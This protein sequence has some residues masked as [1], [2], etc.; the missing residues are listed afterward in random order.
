VRRP[1]AAALVG[2]VALGCAGTI[3]AE[4]GAQVRLLAEQAAA[5]DAV[6]LAQL[7]AVREVDGRRVNL[8]V[9]LRGAQGP[10]LA[11]RLAALGAPSNGAVT[12]V[13]PSGEAARI[14]AEDRFHEAGATRPLRG[15]LGWIGD[16]LEFLERPFG[17]LADRI[18]GGG[19]VLAVLVAL[20]VAGVAAFVASRVARRR[21]GAAVE[22]GGGRAWEDAEDPARLE[23]EADEAEQRGELEAALRLRFRAGLL[24]LERAAVIPADERTS[25]ELRRIVAQPEFDRLAAEFDAVAYGGRAATRNAVAA[26]RSSWR[27]VLE[28]AGR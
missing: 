21:A 5:G 12:S 10:D 23:R 18:P 17:W 24:R 9:A 26:S 20:L 22:R 4:T 1:L 3:G 11:K 28:R 27:T 25:G 13:D 19:S 14:L 6:A 8:A 15:V 16:R 2:A 7:R